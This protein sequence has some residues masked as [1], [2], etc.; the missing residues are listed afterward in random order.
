MVSNEVYL[1]LFKEK[2]S[3]IAI[4]WDWMG[5][6]V[7]TSGHPTAAKEDL[8]GELLY[9]NMY[10]YTYI[11]IYILYTVSKYR[12][13]QGM[14]CN[15]K[16][17]KPVQHGEWENNCICVMKGYK[18][19]WTIEPSATE[20]GQ[21]FLNNL[22]EDIFDDICN[23]ALGGLHMFLENLLN[24]SWFPLMVGHT[25]SGMHCIP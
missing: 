17:F 14:Y 9:I 8:I 10:R 19:C 16:L 15:N 6:M 4:G 5:S 23:E 12:R 3:F 21:C 24:P 7:L 18:A 13:I 25:L 20:L 2:S 1:I 22:I 11:Y